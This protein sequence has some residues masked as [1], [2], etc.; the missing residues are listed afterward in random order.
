MAG[1]SVKHNAWTMIM[2]VHKIGNVGVGLYRAGMVALG[3]NC[4]YITVHIRRHKA[5]SIDGSYCRSL[6]R[7]G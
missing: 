1:M 7:N 4:R 3:G 5:R 2:K 6:F